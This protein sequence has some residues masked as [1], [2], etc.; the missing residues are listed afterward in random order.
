MLK[1]INGNVADWLER[2]HSDNLDPG[3]NLTTVVLSER[4]DP[5]V[6]NVWKPRV[7]QDLVR[8]IG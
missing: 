5:S 1:K 8:E 7:D 6:E 4:V 3:S 2:P